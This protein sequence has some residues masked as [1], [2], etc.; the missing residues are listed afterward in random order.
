MCCLLHG[1]N[2]R[3]REK[4]AQLTSGCC[5]LSYPKST[6]TWNKRKKLS[7]AHFTIMPHNL[8]K[9][10][11]FH[12][13]SLALNAFVVLMHKEETL[14]GNTVIFPLNWNLRRTTQFFREHKWSNK[15]V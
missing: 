3:A 15:C 5:C 7:V 14:P 9:I 11:T 13:F 2:A 8:Y 10:I 12:P 1:Q 4:W 6:Q